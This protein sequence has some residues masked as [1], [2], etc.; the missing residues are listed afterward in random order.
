MN[1]RRLIGKTC[2]FIS[3]G[4]S[5]CHLLDLICKVNRVL[6]V[7][8]RFDIIAFQ[9]DGSMKTID[10]FR[11]T[12]GLG[13]AGMAL[14]YPAGTVAVAGVFQDAVT[15]D[16]AS[17]FCFRT[18]PVAGEKNI[19]NTWY[20]VRTLDDTA[21]LLNAVSAAAAADLIVVAA[22]AADELPLNLY[23]WIEMWLPRR[24]SRMGAL[25]VLIGS[26]E[27]SDSA[28]E[29]TLEYF[30]AVARMGRLE[31]IPQ[32]CALPVFPDRN[33]NLLI[34]L[35]SASPQSS[36]EVYGRRFDVFAIGD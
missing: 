4:S 16:W 29:K 20:D 23:V 35:P 6:H 10:H 13:N 22:Y 34:P 7:L 11:H 17:H 18:T 25:A 9:R 14:E 30:K 26:D 24:F 21:S 15:R 36:A 32:I 33:P 19:Q 2:P 12:L 8:C 1:R 27:P 5:I 31:F 28:R 3:Y